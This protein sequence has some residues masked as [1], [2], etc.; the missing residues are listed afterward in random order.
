MLYIRIEYVFFSF[1]ILFKGWRDA[2]SITLFFMSNLYQSEGLMIFAS[3]EE[4]MFNDESEGLRRRLLAFQLENGYNDH[5]DDTKD[6]EFI[7]NDLRVR[8]QTKIRTKPP[9]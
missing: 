4:P 3:N 1:C 6:L 7:K 8:F 5:S 9:K 2:F